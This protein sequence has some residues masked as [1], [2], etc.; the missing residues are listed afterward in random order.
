MREGRP[1]R[2]GAQVGQVP[3]FSFTGSRAINSHL[4]ITPISVKS[5]GTVSANFCNLGTSSISMSNA[6]V[7]VMTF[8]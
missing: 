7:R 8:G 4:Q 6:P 1:H 5:A 3:V 2:R